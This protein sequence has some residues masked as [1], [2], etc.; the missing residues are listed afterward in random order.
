VASHKALVNWAL[1]ISTSSTYG[2]ITGLGGVQC[3][4]HLQA[5]HIGGVWGSES[6][7]DQPLYSKY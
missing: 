2:R 6:V 5:T 1:G 3:W 4:L 7:V